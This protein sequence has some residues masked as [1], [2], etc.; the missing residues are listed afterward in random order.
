M[1]EWEEK[2]IAEGF[3]NLIFKSHLV[4]TKP[5][6][7]KPVVKKTAKRRTTKKKDVTEYEETDFKDVETAVEKKPKKARTPK[8]TAAKESVETVA[9]ENSSKNHPAPRKQKAKTEE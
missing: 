9:V 2:M 1:A 5:S 4:K 6:R 3:S 7:A 8:M